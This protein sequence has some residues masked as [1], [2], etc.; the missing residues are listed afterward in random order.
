M[1]ILHIISAPASGGAEVYVKD[2]AKQLASQGH[3]LHIAFVSKSKDIG[4]DPSYEDEYLNELHTSGIKSYFIGHECRVK[5]WLGILRINKYLKENDIDICHSHLAYGVAFSSL[6]KTPLV[7][8]Y[9]QSTMRWNKTT[10]RILNLLIDEY[11]G[12]SKICTQDLSSFTNRHV[13]QINN[14]VSFSKF[15]D[16]TRIREIKGNI[17]ICMVGR[18]VPAKDYL[19]M[20]E[21]INLLDADM[22]S[23]IHIQIA[24]EGDYEYKQ[25][26]LTYIKERGLENSVSFIGVLSNIPKFMSN[27]DIFLMSSYTEGLP[28]ALIEASVSGLPCIVTDVGGCSEVVQTCK[29]GI[30]VPPRSPR[31]L[32]DAIAQLINNPNLVKTYS[33]N[34]IEGSKAY[35]IDKA[36]K[37]H[38][39]LYHQALN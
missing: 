5:P 30:V 37:Q 12:I 23:R 20:L 7:Y 16:Y 29:N 34:T 14:A 33:I 8:T 1:N 19:N 39:D 35:S 11:V 38:L 32:A 15:K 24:G 25:E 28:I 9:H 13:T 2:L 3:S 22:K 36:A 4:R 27:S 26:L 21:A 10:F 17:N 31:L 18:I 6:N